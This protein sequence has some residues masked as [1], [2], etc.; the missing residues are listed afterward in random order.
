VHS[1]MDTYTEQI[2]DLTYE[3]AEAGCGEKEIERAIDVVMEIFQGKRDRGVVVC[4]DVRVIIEKK[5]NG[6]GFKVLER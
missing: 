5:R 4:D 6:I 1:E 2:V 3:M